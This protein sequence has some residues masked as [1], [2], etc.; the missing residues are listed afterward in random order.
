M[1]KARNE[2]EKERDGGGMQAWVSR[3]G[4]PDQA[5]PNHKFTLMRGERGP[6]L[7]HRA[8]TNLPHRHSNHP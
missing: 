5:K 7:E 8:Q 6:V 1:T 3:D 2:R 4:P